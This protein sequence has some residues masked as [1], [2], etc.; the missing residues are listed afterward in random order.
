[1]HNGSNQEVSWTGSAWNIPVGTIF[2][3]SSGAGTL[4]AIP[5]TWGYGAEDVLDAWMSATFNYQAVLVTATGHAALGGVT[6][7]FWAATGPTLIAGYESIGGANATG[8]LAWQPVSL[9][10]G[11]WAPVPEP[12]SV[13]LLAIGAAAIGLRRR[14]RK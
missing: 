14:I 2:L 13:A 10:P 7:G 8:F 3:A 11:G 6:D 4:E 9:A 1:M 12:T 5:G